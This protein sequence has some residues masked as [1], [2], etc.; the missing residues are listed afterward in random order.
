MKP[1]AWMWLP[2]EYVS[3]KVIHGQ[4]FGEHSTLKEGAEAEAS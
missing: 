4:N 1:G 2:R 3:D